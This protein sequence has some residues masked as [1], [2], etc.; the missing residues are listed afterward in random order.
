MPDRDDRFIEL[1][2]VFAAPTSSDSASAVRL[3]E[4]GIKRILRE[5]VFNVGHEQFL[6]LLFVMKAQGED[7]ARFPRE[8]RRPRLPINSRT[9]S[10]ID[11]RNR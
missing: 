6:M 7:S 11:S 3:V 1:D 2:K 9:Q 8:A 10:S 4:N 5:D